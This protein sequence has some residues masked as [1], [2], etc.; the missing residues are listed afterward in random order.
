MAKT[1][2]ESM[3]NFIKFMDEHKTFNDFTE[4]VMTTAHEDIN[5]TIIEALIEEIHAAKLITW[6]D[7][8]D[9]DKLEMFL[10]DNYILEL[11]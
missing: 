2:N 10:K 8:I 11:K 3:G 7:G 9:T 5:D 1:L 4:D 6:E